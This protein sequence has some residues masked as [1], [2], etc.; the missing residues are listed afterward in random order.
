MTKSNLRIDIGAKEMFDHTH[1]EFQLKN[2]KINQSEYL[3]YLIEKSKRSIKGQFVEVTFSKPFRRMGVSGEYRDV[4]GWI[5]NRGNQLTY[6]ELNIPY[7]KKNEDVKAAR[8]KVYVNQF[9]KVRGR[10]I[11]DNSFPLK[12]DE[13]HVIQFTVNVGHRASGEKGRREIIIIPY[14]YLDKTDHELVEDIVEIR[15]VS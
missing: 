4:E 9:D 15:F 3:K 2:G 8:L 7:F 14:K 13:G 10:H 1:T 5:L 11:P 12:P 6:I